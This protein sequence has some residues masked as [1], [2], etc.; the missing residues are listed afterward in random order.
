MKLRIVLAA[1]FVFAV[2]QLA[3]STRDAELSVRIFDNGRPTAVRV[4]LSGPGGLTPKARFAVAVS[5]TAMPIPGQAIGVM[6]GQNDRVQGF[7]L[8]PDGSFYVD[9]AFDVRVPPGTYQLTVSKG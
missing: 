2:A 3:Q 8:Q 6:W 4:H 5:E 9:G 7:T 1:L